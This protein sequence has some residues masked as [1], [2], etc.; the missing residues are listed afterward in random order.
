MLTRS[1]PDSHLAYLPNHR[2]STE[3]NVVELYIVSSITTVPFG[4]FCEGDGIADISDFDGD[5]FAFVGIRNDDDEA[6]F[7]AGDAIAL[8]ADGFDLDGTL[9]AFFVLQLRLVSYQI[10][11]ERPRPHRCES[12][13]RMAGERPHQLLHR[14]PRQY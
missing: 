12:V 8:V 13:E 11:C 5:S 1:R 9:V 2:Y 6:A 10:S 14:T 4:D 7:N 3:Q